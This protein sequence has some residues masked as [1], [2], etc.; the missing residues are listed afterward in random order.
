MIMTIEGLNSVLYE[1]LAAANLGISGDIYFD[2]ERPIDSKSEDIAINTP[3]LNGSIGTPQNGYSNI[4]IYVPR[5]RVVIGGKQRLVRNRVRE[6]ALVEAVDAAVK[7]MSVEGI[8]YIDSESKEQS[9]DGN[10]SFVNVRVFWN[11]YYL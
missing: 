2:N 11:I 4:N 8:A 3:A 5:L 6:A 7:S 10:E 9:A 1:A